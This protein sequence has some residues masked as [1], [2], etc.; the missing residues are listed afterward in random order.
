MDK[1]AFLL[2]ANAKL[3]G[4]PKPFKIEYYKDNGENVVVEKA[5]FAKRLTKN[6]KVGHEE[7]SKMLKIKD[8]LNNTF[9]TVHP[10]LII[11]INNIQY[12]GL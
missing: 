12:I 6:P 2:L 4:Q 9:D 11:S 3:H 5:V 1:K 8:L 7:F 10:W